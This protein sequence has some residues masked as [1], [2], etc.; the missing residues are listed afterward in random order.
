MNNALKLTVLTAA[1]AGAGCAINPVANQRLEEA[2]AS[3]RAA[4]ADS[5]V[6]RHAQPEL[7][8]AANALADA[9]RSAM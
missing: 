2:R 3:H 9:E 6:Q 7:Q 1:V 4:A 8:R 5:L